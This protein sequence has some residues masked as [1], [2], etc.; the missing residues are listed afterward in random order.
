MYNFGY[1]L[2]VTVHYNAS[3]SKNVAMR[4]RFFKNM[5]K[6]NLEFWITKIYYKDDLWKMGNVRAV[7]IKTF[8]L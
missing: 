6:L 7:S 1:R 2:G 8:L 5:A 4:V 3:F